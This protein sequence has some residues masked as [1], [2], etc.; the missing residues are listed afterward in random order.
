MCGASLLGN[1]GGNH[2]IALLKSQF[3]QVMEQ[4]CYEKVTDLRDT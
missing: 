1:E 2:T 4:L 3:K